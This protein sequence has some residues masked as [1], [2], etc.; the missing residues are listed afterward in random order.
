MRKFWTLGA[1]LLVATS[2]S[3]PV[4]AGEGGNQGGY[5]KV[6]NNGKQGQYQDGQIFSGKVTAVN[7]NNGTITFENPK[8]GTSQTFTVTANTKI[9]VGDNAGTLANIQVGMYGG[10]RSQ[11]GKTA[12]ELRASGGNKGGGGQGGQGQAKE[13]IFFGQV[14]AVNANNSTVAFQPKDGAAQTF[15]IPASAKIQVQGQAGSLANVQ[16]GMYGG[17]K[18]GGNN[19][20]LEM[21]AWSDGQGDGKG[22]NKGGQDKGGQDKG[23]QNTSGR[24]AGK[25]YN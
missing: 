8:Q 6:G 1:A 9:Q 7:A 10:A 2:L 23:G 17:V 25:T 13:S 24:R 14:T 16:V 5:N 18:L 12:V 20:V 3:L 4:M 15:T 21:R 22:Q 11:D 19:A